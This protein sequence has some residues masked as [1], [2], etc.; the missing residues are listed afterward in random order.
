LIDNALK[1]LDPS[2]PGDI[3]IEGRESGTRTI[4]EVRDNGRGIDTK[5]HARI[6][7]LFR[8]SGPARATS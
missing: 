8:R 6:F 4:Y 2:R 1:Y 5:D 7:E 3:R